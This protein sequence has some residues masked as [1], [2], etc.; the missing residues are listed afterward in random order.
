MMK[1]KLNCVLHFAAAH[2]LT[3]YH[4][5]CEN[6]HGHNYKVIIT[7]EGDVKEDGMVQDYKEIKK[8][9]KDNVVDQLDHTSLND[10][11]E[12]PSSENLAVFIWDRIKKELPLLTK[13]TVFETEDYYC[14][15]EGK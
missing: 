2:F 11:M 14:E 8:I 4:G 15:Y 3:K 6:L 12:N 13:V 10:V 1:I 9:V 7:L 5:K